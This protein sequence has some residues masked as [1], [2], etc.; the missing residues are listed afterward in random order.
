MTALATL[1]SSFVLAS[2]AFASG[3]PIP[4]RYTCDGADVSPALRWTRPPLGTRSFS[5]WVVDLDT[6][7]PFR[8]WT[9]TGISPT[10]RRLAVGSRTGRSRRNDFGRVGYGGPCP[11]P[12]QTHRYRFRLIALGARGRVLG[13]ATLVG[14]YRRHV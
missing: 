11:P 8:H 9:V 1:V 6:H 4:P 3:H 13:A 14:T 2:P 12:G 7:P 10:A 5:L